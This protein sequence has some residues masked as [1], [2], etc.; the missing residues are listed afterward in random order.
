MDNSSSKP[1]KSK[2]ATLSDRTLTYWRAANAW[3]SS[4]HTA[5]NLTVQQALEM[6]KESGK[7]SRRLQ[8][9]SNKILNQIITNQSEGKAY[10]APN[11]KKPK[12]SITVVSPVPPV[13]SGD[14]SGTR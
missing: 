8:G 3:H 13:S 2:S 4:A 1:S 5:Q 11:K 6:L 12:D 14:V 9:L 10:Y 7:G